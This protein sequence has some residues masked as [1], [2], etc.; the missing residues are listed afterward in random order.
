M[1]Y[2]LKR[3]RSSSPHTLL[4][5]CFQ[6]LKPKMPRHAPSPPESGCT[7]SLKLM[8]AIN[9]IQPP[10]SPSLLLPFSFPNPHQFS[11]LSLVAV[12][13]LVQSPSGLAPLLILHVWAHVGPRELMH[14][15]FGQ[16][17]TTEG[18]SGPPGSG[19]GTV[20]RVVAC[21]GDGESSGG[22]GT[23]GCLA[24]EG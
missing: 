7:H 9:P 18:L 24:Q 17:E 1:V 16:E 6:D 13:M 14:M 11:Q 22:P 19:S 3:S 2:V 23:P 21:L 4:L 5:D 20:W 10:L 8:R 15:L 12:C